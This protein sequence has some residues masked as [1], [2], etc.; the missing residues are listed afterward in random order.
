MEKP[1]VVTNNI[2]ADCFGIRDYAG[3]EGGKP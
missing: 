3:S 1:E 2:S